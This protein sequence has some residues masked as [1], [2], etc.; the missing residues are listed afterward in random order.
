MYTVTPEVGELWRSLFAWVGGRAGE[1]LRYLPHAAPAPLE[2]LWRRHDL[3][4]AFVCGY[5]FARGTFPLN[6]VAVPVPAAE[7]YGGRPVYA[8]D[9]VVRA[10]GPFRA[11]SDTFGGRIGWTAEHSQSGYHAIRSHLGRL[12]TGRPSPPFHEAVGPLLTPR[13]VIEAVLG[14]AIDVGPLDSYY[15]DLLLAHD[16]GTAS[17]LRVVDTTSLTPMPLLAAS[18]ETPPGTIV[19]LQ[20]ALFAATTANE[21]APLLRALRIT[22]FA[23]ANE[24]AYR[25][26]LAEAAS[27]VALAG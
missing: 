14:G 5:P 2:A 20:E 17:R 18:A 26:L 15:H 1:R 13:G 11:L 23:P 10:D 24:A 19:R 7:R 6:A 9:L 27:G 12:R 21:I 3:G 25:S 16:S 22:G 8:T 4:V